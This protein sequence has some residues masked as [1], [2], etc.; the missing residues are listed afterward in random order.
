[1]KILN[2][3]NKKFWSFAHNSNK[4]A[5]TQKKITSVK[6]DMITKIVLVMFVTTIS[7]IGASSTTSFIVEGSIYINV[8]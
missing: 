3:D 8:F 4:E 6:E 5:R 2:K 1:M 7:V